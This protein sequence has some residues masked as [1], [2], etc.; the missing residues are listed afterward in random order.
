M[1][2]NVFIAVYTHQC[3]SYCDKEFFGNLFASDIGSA[4]VAIVDNSLDADYFHTLYDRY[5]MHAY[6]DHIIVN[7]GD[8]KTQ[9]VRNVEASLYGLRRMFLGGDYEY[10]IILESDVKPKDKMWLHY[11]I[12]V[13]DQADII[14]GL[15]YEGFHAPDM[16]QG[17]SRIIS[18][19]HAL[20]GC[21]L[22]KRS[23]L[24]RFAFRSV[25]ENPGVF[26]DA[27]MCLDAREAGFKIANY[28]KIQ[29]THLVDN[30]GGRGIENIN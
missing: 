12:E 19:H 16:W 29:C 3:K 11:F 23:V 15:Y 20:S 5:N 13:V 9:F 6:V 14:G 17:P 8:S 18:T 26:P 2:E 27:L 30:H 22:Y 4:S 25:A 10:F 21:T 28:T 1:F 7:R 24:E